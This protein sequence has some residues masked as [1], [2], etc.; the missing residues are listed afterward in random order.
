MIKLKEGQKVLDKNGN[1]YLIEKGDVIESQKLK[2]EFTEL[3]EFRTLEDSVDSC[4][5][6]IKQMYKTWYKNSVNIDN[7]EWNDYGYKNLKDASLSAKEE[8]L[9]YITYLAEKEI[10]SW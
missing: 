6:N 1:T 4:L 8:I 3:Q 7:D 10:K 9:S 5:S 2:E